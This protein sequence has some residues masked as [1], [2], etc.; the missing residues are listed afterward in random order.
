MARGDGQ[1]RIVLGVESDQVAGQEPAEL[2]I[3]LLPVALTG[4]R[5]ELSEARALVHE[6]TAMTPEQADRSWCEQLG[7]EYRDVG[8][9]QVAMERQLARWQLNHPHAAGL[10]ELAE[11]VAG[12]EPVRQA[13][14]Q[15]LARLNCAR[16]QC[17]PAS[18][19]QTGSSTDP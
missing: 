5:A 11:L 19:G 14:L 13:L 16:D 10:D 12:V 17:D 6:L 1:V 15:Q 2:G 9:A 7:N 4:L 18:A 3:E 8:A